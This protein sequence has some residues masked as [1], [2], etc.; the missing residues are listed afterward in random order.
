MA[1]VSVD[2]LK[3]LETAKKYAY[4]LAALL[5]FLAYF[6]FLFSID[7]MIIV[8]LGFILGM[9]LILDNNQV[10]KYFNDIFKKGNELNN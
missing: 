5:S 6:Y 10:Q 8:F 4:V 3:K 1:I 2:I 9:V 7:S